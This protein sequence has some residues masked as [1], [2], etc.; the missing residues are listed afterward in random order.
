VGGAIGATLWFTRRADAGSRPRWYA[1]SSPTPAVAFG[2]ALYLGLGVLDFFA[3]PST[4]ET[5]V[6]ALFAV[7]SL[8]ALRIVVHST[9]LHEQPDGAHPDDPVLCPQCE[10]VVPDLAF[11]ARCGVAG[12]ASSRTSRARRRSTRPVPASP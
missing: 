10:H 11:C 6:Y 1:L 5:I 8:Y 2:V 9:L 12:H 3:P 7:L 4:V